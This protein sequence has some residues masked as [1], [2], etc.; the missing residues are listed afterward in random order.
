MNPHFAKKKR[1]LTALQFF[2]MTKVFAC[3]FVKKKRMT[4]TK[5]VHISHPQ[6]LSNYIFCNHFSFPLTRKQ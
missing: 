5:I 2:M 6:L 1:S 3:L 4:R